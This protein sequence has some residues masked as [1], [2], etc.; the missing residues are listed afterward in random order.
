MFMT[1]AL[2][3][4]EIIK[5]LQR[6]TIAKPFINKYKLIGISFPWEKDDWKKPGE[7]NLTIALNFFCTKNITCLCLKI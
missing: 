7:N 3:H 5:E 4:G 2:N 1:A 6:I